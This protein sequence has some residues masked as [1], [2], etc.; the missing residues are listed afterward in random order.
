MTLDPLNT[1]LV[2]LGKLI[3]YLD[4]PG[5]LSGMELWIHSYLI[6]EEAKVNLP[7]LLEKPSSASA[8]RGDRSDP[9]LLQDTQSQSQRHVESVFLK[10]IDEG[11]CADA[12]EEE[13]INGPGADLVSPTSFGTP[14]QY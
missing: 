12:Q 1:M 2:K 11:M 14:R 5:S 4:S 6:H 13:A 7:A 10:V 9:Q 3:R 8:S